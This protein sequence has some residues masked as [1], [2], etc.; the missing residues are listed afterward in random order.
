MVHSDPLIVDLIKL[1][2]V[3]GFIGVDSDGDS[4]GLIM[5]FSP[6]CGL[7]N[8]FSINLGLF[9]NLYYKEMD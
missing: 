1:L 5:G 6:S 8:Y 7:I 4:G 2:S 9:T 3:W